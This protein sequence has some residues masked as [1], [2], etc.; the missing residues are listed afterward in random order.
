MAGDCCP[1]WFCALQEERYDHRGADGRQQHTGPGPAADMPAADEARADDEKP[2][3]EGVLAD[4]K[5]QAPGIQGPEALAQNAQVWF[6]ES[7]SDSVL[8]E[9]QRASVAFKVGLNVGAQGGGAG[10]VRNMQLKLLKTSP[11]ILRNCMQEWPVLQT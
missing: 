5:E 1:L 10:V 8:H 9:I 11:S 6:S 4:E 2:D 3:A 7:A